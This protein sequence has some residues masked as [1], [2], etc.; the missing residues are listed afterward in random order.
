MKEVW[1]GVTS[2][3]I[4][5]FRQMIEIVGREKRT[6]KYPKINSVFQFC[7]H[8]MC[9]NGSLVCHCLASAENRTRRRLEAVPT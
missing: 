1:T 9:Q 6:I 4:G 5:E 7:I 8:D 2:L 3:V